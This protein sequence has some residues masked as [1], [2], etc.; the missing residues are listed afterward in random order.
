MVEVAALAGV[1]P[2]TVS[3][4]M[5]AY[6]HVRPDVRERVQAAAAELGYRPDVRGR[7]LATGRTSKIALAVP[8]LRLPYFAEL[9]HDVIAV[10]SRLGLHVL[11]RETNASREGE[12]AA[13]RSW[14]SGIVDGML[15][16]AA[17]LTADE[18][19]ATRG[20]LPLVQLGENPVGGAFD[21]VTAD[22]ETAARQVAEHLIRAGRRRIAFLGH[23]AD[24]LTETSRQRLAGYRAALAA[25]GLA[26]DPALVIPREHVGA[27]E[28]VTALRTALESGIRP[29]AIMCRDDL[30]AIGALHA[31]KAAGLSCPEDVAVTGWDDIALATVVDPPLTTIRVDREELV[32][33]ALELLAERI[34]GEDSAGRHAQ[35]G[36]RLVI[37]ASAPA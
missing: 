4:V 12:Q 24:E 10:A 14:E 22:D 25:A 11:V 36:H 31:L 28:T 19:L 21:Q 16:Y 32:R 37:R 20:D 6:K 27:D 17:N 33:L 2:K 30:A 26:E 35:V 23:E 8:D 7:S 29:D 34:D 15:Y 5:R 1:S 9:A 3:N 18:I 13:L